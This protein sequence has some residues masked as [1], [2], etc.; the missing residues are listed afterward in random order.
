VP[1]LIPDVLSQ[2][3]IEEALKGVVDSLLHRRIP[4]EEILLQQERRKWLHLAD[5]LQ[6]REPVSVPCRLPRI[7]KN[8]WGYQS[9]ENDLLA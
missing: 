1:D 8:W 7:H 3:V 2:N 4:L 6:V 9:L 5:H